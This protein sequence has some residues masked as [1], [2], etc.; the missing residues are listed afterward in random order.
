MQ[1]G[2]PFFIELSEA[3]RV[4]KLLAFAYLQLLS[5]IIKIFYV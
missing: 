5:P 1:L 2:V 4:C 3:W